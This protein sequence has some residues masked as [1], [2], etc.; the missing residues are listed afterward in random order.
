MTRPEPGE[1]AGYFAKY[2]ERVPEGDIVAVL[3]AQLPETLAYYGAIPEEKTLHRYAPGKWSIKEN[4][5]HISDSERVMAYRALRFARNDRTALPGFEQDDFVAAAD[6]D[7]RSW[8]SILGEFDAVRR[9]TL[10]LFEGLGKEA[11]TRS[12]TANGNALSV[13]ALAYVIAGHVIHHQA[14]VEEKYGVIRSS[15]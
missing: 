6:A 13:R 7:A 3:R 9:A 8:G 12:G 15:G 14:V 11:W 1:Y 5:V 4:L 2:V 10:A